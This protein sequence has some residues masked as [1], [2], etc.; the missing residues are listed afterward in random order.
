MSSSSLSLPQLYYN[1][2]EKT[3]KLGTSASLLQAST[4]LADKWSPEATGRRNH[5]KP[6]LYKAVLFHF[7]LWFLSDCLG[8][9]GAFCDYASEQNNRDPGRTAVTQ[10]HRMEDTGRDV[11][12]P[13]ATASHHKM[14]K[15]NWGVYHQTKCQKLHFKKWNLFWLIDGTLTASWH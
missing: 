6:S 1:K 12:S 8:F 10:L 15:L 13:L 5:H 14:E 7:C 9:L 3:E 2:Y 4:N 11:Q